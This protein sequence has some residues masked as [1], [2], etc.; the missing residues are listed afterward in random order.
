MTES[1]IPGPTSGS[2]RRDLLRI[3]RLFTE[4][5]TSFDGQCLI[6]LRLLS[7]PEPELAMIARDL[8]AKR[9]AHLTAVVQAGIERGEISPTTDVRLLLDMLSGTLQLRIVM[10]NEAVDD[11]VIGRVVDTLLAGVRTTKPVPRRAVK[12]RRR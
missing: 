6:R 9:T 2:I 7:H 10:R 4:F 5:A 11:V 8:H 3:G 1:T 12:R